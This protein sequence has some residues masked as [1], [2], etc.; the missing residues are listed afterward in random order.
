M[1][2]TRYTAKGAHRPAPVRITITL[3]RE[4]YDTL[5]RLAPSPREREQFVLKAIY[6]MMKKV[7]K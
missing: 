6:E 3:S 5:T 2:L 4:T 7:T 1:D